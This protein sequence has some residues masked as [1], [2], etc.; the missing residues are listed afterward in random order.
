MLCVYGGLQLLRP[1]LMR[2]HIMTLC[3]SAALAPLG[4][5]LQVAY[6]PTRAGQAAFVRCLLAH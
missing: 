2:S 1:I 5:R 3:S 6:E 4:H